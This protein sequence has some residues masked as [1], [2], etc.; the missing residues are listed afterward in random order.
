MSTIG[1][2]RLFRLVRR[3]APAGAAA[4]ALVVLT[5]TVI[6]V[7]DRQP[8]NSRTLTILYTSQARSQVRSCN[9]TKFRFGG[10]GR[11]ATFVDK[12]RGDN[13]NLILVEGGDFVGEPKREQER[14][15][16]DVAVKAV[17]WIR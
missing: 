14:L 1:L 15:K 11:Q 2:Q 16:A 3:A 8:A 10:Y 17:G 5:V 13:K 12:I 4:A 9:C 7:N 6:A